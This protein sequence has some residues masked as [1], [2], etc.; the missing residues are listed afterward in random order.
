V[1]GKK[2]TNGGRVEELIL[3]QTCPLELLQPEDG[4]RK[5]IRRVGNYIPVYMASYPRRLESSDC[6]LP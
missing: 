6:A 1:F 2:I 3:P 4:S 5:F